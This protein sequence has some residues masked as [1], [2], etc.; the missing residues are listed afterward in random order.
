MNDSN[1][2]AY[3]QFAVTETAGKIPGVEDV[4]E[5]A[6]AIN[7]AD[8]RIFTRYR[9]RIIALGVS[10]SELAQAINAFNT[11]IREHID[12]EIPTPESLNLEN[13]DNFASSNSITLDKANSFATSRSVYQLNRKL[14]QMITELPDHSGTLSTLSNAINVLTE[15]NTSLVAAL[16]QSEQK[17]VVAE[18]TIREHGEKIAELFRLHDAPPVPERTSTIVRKVIPAKGIHLTPERLTTI[19][20]SIQHDG[21]TKDSLLANVTSLSLMTGDHT[22]W[23]VKDFIN[24]IQLLAMSSHAVDDSTYM[25]KAIELFMYRYVTEGWVQPTDSFTDIDHFV[26]AAH[27]VLV[28]YSWL[29]PNMTQEQRDAVQLEMQKW[30]DHWMTH[31]DY[32]NVFAGDK[33][34]STR[35]RFAFAN[36]FLLFSVTIVNAIK[37]NRCLVTFDHLQQTLNQDIVFANMQTGMWDLGTN[38]NVAVMTSYLRLQAYMNE[39][40]DLG[41]DDDYNG[42]MWAAF[43][44]QHLSVDAGRLIEFGVSGGQP[45]NIPITQAKEYINLFNMFEMVLTAPS[46]IKE[47]MYFKDLVSASNGGSYGAMT[48]LVEDLRL[49]KTKPSGNTTRRETDNGVLQI[50]RSTTETDNEVMAITTTS[51]DDEVVRHEPMGLSVYSEGNLVTGPTKGPSLTPIFNGCTINNHDGYLMGKDT[52][53][54]GGIR[55]LVSSS[56]VDYMYLATDAKDATNRLGPGLVTFCNQNTRTVFMLPN[57][58]ALVTYD[59]IINDPNQVGDLSVTAP[60]DRNVRRVHR[61]PNGDSAASLVNGVYTGVYNGIRQHLRSLAGAATI[62]HEPSHPDFENMSDNTLASHVREEIQSSDA[63]F[64]SVMNYG[65]LAVEPISAKLLSV[66]AGNVIAVLVNGDTCIL[67]NKNP[68]VPI[69]G[70][71]EITDSAVSAI[72][73]LYVVGQAVGQ[74]YDLT[75]AGN[76]L[77][78]INGTAWAAASD[79]VSTITIAAPDPGPD[80][81]PDPDP[82]PTEPTSFDAYTDFGVYH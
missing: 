12:Q 53:A 64:I 63:E 60:Y 20:E 6:L 28:T 67:I 52:E 41:N 61:F 8:K 19:F 30:A 68:L 3:K 70:T 13:V 62:I 39:L 82:N 76:T 51:F 44:E 42:N 15:D 37:S 10:E 33:I 66:D 49:E 74:E 22:L 26:S 7:I 27:K 14:E 77:T 71:I 45:T 32:A 11:V 57:L 1:I 47:V 56:A 80:P 29:S 73:K 9:N 46:D 54:R 50:A 65:G 38:N 17:L 58:K 72:R 23:P 78:L 5:R 25:D 69:T 43:V 24:R 21:S 16:A 79:G 31:A 48:L 18:D 4:G 59:H 75:V 36:I 2:P 34:K 81:D 40:T 55:Q 35:D